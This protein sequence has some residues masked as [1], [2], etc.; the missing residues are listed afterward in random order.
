[1]M[2]G[3]NL[4]AKLQIFTPGKKMKADIRSGKETKMYIKTRKVKERRTNLFQSVG[5]GLSPSPFKAKFVQSDSRCKRG[6]D[7][8]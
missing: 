1:M 3:V 6:P 4:L 8:T 5:N 7:A 2:C